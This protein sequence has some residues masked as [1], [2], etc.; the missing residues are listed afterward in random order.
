MA[1]TCLHRR[2]SAAP[3]KQRVAH[4]CGWQELGRL[5]RRESAAPLKQE[6]ACWL[7][8]RVQESPPTRIGG[9][10]EARRAAEALGHVNGRSPP[11]R[12]GGSI[13]APLGAR[14]ARR[15]P[16]VS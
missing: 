13:E 2:E 16:S 3:L 10:I 1:R 7:L 8:R 4:V 14:S 11:T 9:S 6:S 5:R 12:I 15:T